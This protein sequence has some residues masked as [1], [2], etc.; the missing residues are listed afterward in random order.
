[1]KKLLIILFITIN[2]SLF[3]Q[4]VTTIGGVAYNITNDPTKVAVEVKGMTN[5]KIYN[6]TFYSARTPE[7]AG[8]GLV[9][10]CS[11]Y[12]LVPSTPSRGTKI[13]NNI[14]YTKHQIINININDNDCLPEFESDYNLFYCEDG[15]PLFK[16]NNVENTF[17][18]WQALGY[19]TH[20]V[21]V[22]P[23]FIDTTDFVPGARLN[24][25]TDLGST[26][27]TGLS[28]NVTSGTTDPETA[29]QNGTWQVGARIYGGRT[30][31]KYD[32]NSEIINLYPNPNDGR[33]LIEF[34]NPLQNDKSEIIITDLAGK[35]VYN[36]LVLKEE[37]LKQFD[38]SSSKPGIYIM[39]IKD[40][41]ILITKKFI[42]K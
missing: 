17:A 20:S 4:T 23:D 18:Q 42:I 19:D 10:I 35:Q 33:F 15:T 39:M 9:D 31:I 40:K 5:F 29:V 1:M 16:V 21:V 25:G 26:W 12:D 38:L 36:G 6:N 34:I 37:I 32:S 30:T 22:N 8:R 27:Q 7:E 13:F 3:S 41:E 28:T 2:S 24:Y 11:D 14:F